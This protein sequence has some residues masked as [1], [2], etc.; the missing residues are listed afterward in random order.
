MARGLY[1]IENPF[2]KQGKRYDRRFPVGLGKQV[3]PLKTGNL[4]N[5]DRCLRVNDGFTA[6]AAFVAR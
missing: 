2:H 5:G 1:I 3:P 6:V 4:M